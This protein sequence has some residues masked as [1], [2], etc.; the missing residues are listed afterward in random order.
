MKTKNLY[1][2]SFCI[3]I[4]FLFTEYQ[5]S[6][7][8]TEH[9]FNDSIIHCNYIIESGMLNGDFKSFYPDGNPKAS[10][11]FLNNNRVGEWIVWD[12][13]GRIIMKRNYRNNFDF[14]EIYPDKEQ[15]YSMLRDKDCKNSIQL[16]DV[17]EPMVVYYQRIW[18]YFP[19]ENNEW[20][21][22]DNY[23][24]NLLVKLIFDSQIQAYKAVNDEF[25][26]P[27]TVEEFKKTF[28]LK[29][30]EIIGYKIKET[31]FIDSVRKISESRIIGICPVAVNKT[32]KLKSFDL[33]WLYYPDIRVGLTTE[34]INNSDPFIRSLDD[35][36]IFRY[37]S[38]IIYKEDNVYDKEIKDYKSG[39]AEIDK[40]AER[41]MLKM[42]ET[43]HDYWI[44]L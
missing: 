25:T 44:S 4:F 40:E 5:L 7:Q 21:F 35:V 41:I 12:T 9:S 14:N 37:F 11:K 17:K 26:K 8:K 20:M 39:K 6:A 19:I 27:F 33:C 16:F 31:F 15:R 34:K 3:L 36:F 1:L 43:E 42:L 30:I 29:N 18:R 23:L 24:R 10:G 28:D 32:D 38:S 2:V 13:T 22:K